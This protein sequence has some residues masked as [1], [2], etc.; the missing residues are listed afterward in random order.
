[1][2]TDEQNQESKTQIEA[3]SRVGELVLFP[4]VLLLPGRISKAVNLGKYTLGLWSKA[5]LDFG[6]QCWAANI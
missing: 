6:R 5:S 2:R 1:M 3:T 4:Q